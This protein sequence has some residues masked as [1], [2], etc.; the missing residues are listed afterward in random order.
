M[1]GTRKKAK[2]KRKE[3]E[4]FHTQIRDFLM[5]AKKKSLNE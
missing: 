1:N 3:I 2:R 4:V 5:G